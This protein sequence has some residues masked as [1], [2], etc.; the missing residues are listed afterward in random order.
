MTR[1]LPA[2]RR[3]VVKVGTTSLTDASGRLDDDQV[4]ALAGELS[5]ARRA[6]IACAFVSSGAIAAGLDPLS[7]GKRPADIPTLQAA[8]SVGQG[9]LMHAYQRAFAR[10]KV[11]VGQVL[12]TQDDFVRRKGYLNAHNALERLLALGVVP[13]VNENDTVA[14]DEIRFGDNDRLAALVSIMVRADLLVLLSD[15]DGVYS[16]DPKRKGARLLPKVDDAASL[17]LGG[18]GSPLSSGGMAS[19]IESVRIAASAGCGVVIANGRAPRVLSQILGGEEVGTFFPPHRA[20]GRHRKLWIEFVQNPR[21]RV[22]VDEGA[23]AALVERGKSLLPAGVTGFSGTFLS[24]DAVEV[25]GPDGTV[26]ARGLI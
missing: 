23:R 6:G 14:V 18:K 21:G 13:I 10:R 16:D 20:R 19:K 3:L 12:L 11:P 5:E 9:I 8:A 26:F 25:A 2:V 7:L 17:K 24:G 4:R 22:E 15:V 1:A